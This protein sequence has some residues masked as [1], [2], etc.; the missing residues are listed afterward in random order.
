MIVRES[1]RGPAV[2]LLSGTPVPTGYFAPLEEALS[3]RFRVLVPA[4]PGYEGTPALPEPYALDEASACIETALLLRGV[5]RAAVVGYSLGAY[6]ALRL[7]LRGRIHVER[8]VMLGGF[9]RLDDD[10]KAGYRQFAQ[11]L[12]EGVDLRDVFV[13]IALAPEFLAKHPEV[14]AELYTWFEAP[15]PGVLAAEL[16]AL[17]EA[18]DLRPRLGSL[19]IPILARVGDQDQTTPVVRS[20][21]IG[22]AAPNVTVQIVPGCGHV[23]LIEDR[24]G[25]V[26]ATTEFLGRAL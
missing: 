10:G 24:E 18:E 16:H 19:A 1:G 22:N 6:R 7:A 25:T 12:R 13:S 5:D 9:A 26:A 3:H 23:Y 8:I 11:Q 20:D 14:K 21:E 17:S 2:V 15:A 4:L